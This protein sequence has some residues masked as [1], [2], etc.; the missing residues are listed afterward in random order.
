MCALTEEIKEPRNK[1]KNTN[2]GSDQVLKTN[3]VQAN[4]ISG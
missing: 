4:K 1:S 2:A 3:V